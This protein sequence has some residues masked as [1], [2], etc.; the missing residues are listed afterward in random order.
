M[1][2]YLNKL[3]SFIVVESRGAIIMYSLVYNHVFRS[4]V[5]GAVINY[6]IYL[7]RAATCEKMLV[8]MN[9]QLVLHGLHLHTVT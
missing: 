7:T 5:N 4:M 1:L 2:V 6:L 9:A 8:V 3:F